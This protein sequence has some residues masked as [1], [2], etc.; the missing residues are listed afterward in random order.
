M[1]KEPFFSIITCTKNS[2]RFLARNIKSVS[3]QTFKNFEHIF[4]DGGSSDKTLEMIKDYQRKYPQKV[5][6]FLRK[7]K[8]I[9]DAMNWG[10]RKAN[11]KYLIHLHSDDGFYNKSVLKKV[12]NIL[13]QK[14]DLDWIYGMINVIDD[15]NKK[16]G[17]FPQRKVFQLASHYLLKFFNFIPHQAVFIKREIFDKFGLFDES[18]PITMD[19]DYWLKIAGK[20]KWQFTDTIVSDYMVRSDAISSSPQ[21]KDILLENKVRVQKRYL[22]KLECFFA[23]LLNIFFVRHNK[24]YKNVEKEG[25]CEIIIK[26]KND[27]ISIDFKELW[28]YRE[29]L[30]IFAWR[31][32][33]IRY[34]QTL[35]GVTWVLLQPLMTTFVFTIF[36]GKLAKIPSDNLPYSLF[37]L[38]GL[39]FWNFFSGSLSRSSNS[40][41]DNENIIK[42]VY[43]PRVILPLSSIVV[44]FID[45]LISCVLL[46]IFS[47]ILGYVPSP[48]LLIIAPLALIISS[49]TAGGLGLFLSAVNV[50]YRDVKYI[51]PFFIQILMFLTPVI[52]PTSI[53]RPSNR[54]IM[55]LNPMTGVIEA[56]RTAFSGSNLYD[57]KILAASTLFSVVIFVIGQLFFKRTER[58]FA[59]MI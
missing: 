38:I 15:E 12:F 35:L 1:N 29:L 31:D 18:L 36:F 7:P 46:L 49:L 44:N 25:V 8:G 42:K 55:T 2:D 23:K 24:L 9:A 47:L 56:V 10:I 33:K 22:N 6:L 30:Y 52:Y 48:T 45:F 37:V 59:D 14:P 11:G 16:I 58:Y 40:L 50:K 41:L 4:I 5:K 17:I 57:W 54:I 43:F 3:E 53:V 19:Y 39:V 28:R 26:P 34:K 32:I 51:L 27:L 20:T 13:S 21:N